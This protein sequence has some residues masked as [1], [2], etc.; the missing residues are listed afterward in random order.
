MHLRPT[1]L[2]A[3]SENTPTTAVENNRHSLPTN[4]DKR[5]ESQDTTKADTAQA[6]LQTR[7]QR[8]RKEPYWFKDYEIKY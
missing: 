5:T 2:N 8:I 7:P 6:N 3:P 1:T 4:T